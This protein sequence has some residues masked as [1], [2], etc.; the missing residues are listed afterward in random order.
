MKTT[1]ETKA[2]VESIFEESREEIR[3]RLVEKTTNMLF[4]Q[5]RYSLDHKLNNMVDEYLETEIKPILEERLAN[6]KGEMVEACVDAVRATQEQIGEMLAEKFVVT[7]TKALEGY[8]GDRFL[9]ELLG[10]F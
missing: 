10:P 3:E 7:V 5:M 4:E 9:K 8:R 6:V 2:L 1:D